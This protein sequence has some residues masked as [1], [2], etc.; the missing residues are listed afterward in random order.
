[1]RIDAAQQFEQSV[2]ERL[3]QA[4]NTIGYSFADVHK[5]IEDKGAVE[6]AKILVSPNSAGKIHEGL[7]VLVDNNLGHLSIERAVID[8]RKK[9]LFSE[10][11]ISSAEARLGMAEMP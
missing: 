1:M 5:I 9:G 6:A 3:A 10:D 2:K 7:Q 8:F 11:E 4:T